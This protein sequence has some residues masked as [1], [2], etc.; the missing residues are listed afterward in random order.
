[1]DEAELERR[2][3]ELPPQPSTANRR[4]YDKLYAEQ[5]LQADEGCDFT[6]LQPVKG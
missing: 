1:V 2:R 3:A 6:M 5:V 4:G